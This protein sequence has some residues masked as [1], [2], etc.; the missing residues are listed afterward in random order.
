MNSWDIFKIL[1]YALDSEWE[2]SK[3]VVLGDFLSEMNPFIFEGE[4]SADPV[5]YNEFKSKF[6][7]EFNATCKID[8][9]YSFCK[10]YIEELN[11]TEIIDAFNNKKVEDWIKAYKD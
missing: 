4:G 10:K 1:Y 9:G 2:K 7:E 11:K 3:N 8:E 5:I 6:N